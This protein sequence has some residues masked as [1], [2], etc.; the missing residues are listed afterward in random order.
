MKIITTLL[1]SL[2]LAGCISSDLKKSEQLLQDFH[3]AKIDTEQMP[4]SSMTDYYQ[5]MLYSSKAKVES[6]IKQY[7]QGKELFDLPLHEVVE[8]QYDLY[9]DACQNLGGILSSSET[10]S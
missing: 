10:A 4:H 6:Y 1:S 9:K 3:C 5:Q 2:L 7:H 8:Q